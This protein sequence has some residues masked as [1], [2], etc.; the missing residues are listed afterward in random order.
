M[1]EV[2]LTKMVFDPTL[3][4]NSLDELVQLVAKTAPA[5]TD[6]T[7]EQTIKPLVVNFTQSEVGPT[8]EAMNTSFIELLQ[9]TQYSTVFDL[10]IVDTQ[11]HAKIT[12]HYKIECFPTIAVF[13]N[14]KMA[15]Q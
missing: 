1:S 10:K 8:C 6:S 15:D 5:K 3:C 14:G 13:K 2:V 7:K 11:N 12:E 4:I 9:S